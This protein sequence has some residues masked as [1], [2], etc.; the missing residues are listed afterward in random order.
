MNSL[1]SAELRRYQTVGTES[2]L[3]AAR[4]A[5]VIQLMLDGAVSRLAVT[6]G[7]IERGDTAGGG[8]A[9]GQTVSLIGGLRD[10]LDHASGGELAA[11]LDALYDYMIRTLLRAHLERDLVEM[12][13]VARLLDDVLSLIHI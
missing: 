12:D 5:Q 4:P 10:S 2:L 8:R 7:C 9:L 13:D 11:R 1:Q 3:A 6:R